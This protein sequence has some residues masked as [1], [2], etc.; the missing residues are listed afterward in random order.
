M[1]QREIIKALVCEAESDAYHYFEI[2]NAAAILFPKNLIE[3]L[4]QIVNGPVWDGD[5]L[6]KA[7]R[8]DLFDMGLAVR[9]CANGEQGYTGATYSAFTILKMIKTCRHME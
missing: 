9:V 6:C 2:M 8:S 7:D 3:Q 1:K 4:R 5:I